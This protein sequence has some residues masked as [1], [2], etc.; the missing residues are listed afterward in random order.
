MTGAWSQLV[1]L[2]TAGKFTITVA[3]TNGSG[4]SA[5]ATVEARRSLPPLIVNQPAEGVPVT[6]PVTSAGN[7]RPVSI[8]GTAQPGLGPVLIGDGDGRFFAKRTEELTVRGDGTFSGEIDLDFGHH[9]LKF[10][11]HFKDLDGEGVIRNV[12]VPP[13]VS[14][15]AI[16]SIVS[17][18]VEIAPPRR[19]D[20]RVVREREGDGRPRPNGHV[21]GHSPAQP[22]RHR[23]RLS[24]H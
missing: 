24:G 6:R 10:Y 20:H 9:K 4:T 3:Q 22:A 17:A 11:Q 13:P 7:A 23:R 12:P 15:L 16:T 21:A 2:P 1:T 8:S 18:G 19:R 5:P 14:T